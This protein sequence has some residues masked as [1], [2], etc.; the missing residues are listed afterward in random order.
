MESFHEVLIGC[1]K[2]ADA[3]GFR[4]RYDR[5]VAGLD[6]S[7]DLPFMARMSMGAKWKG[8]PQQQRDKFKAL[9]RRH[10]RSIRSDS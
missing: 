8:L 4:G 5:I 6:E 7:F 2:E 9:S 3:L 1:M 10:L